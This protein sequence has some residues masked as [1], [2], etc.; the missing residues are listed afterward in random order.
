MP[1]VIDRSLYLV[2]VTA[3]DAVNSYTCLWSCVLIG[4]KFVFELNMK[5]LRFVCYT[6]KP[7]L[8]PTL[9][10]QRSRVG[11]N[12]ESPPPL[13]QRAMRFFTMLKCPQLAPVLIQMNPAHN[14]LPHVSKI[15]FNIT[16]ASISK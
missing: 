16:L 13:F 3:S 6:D 15:H 14:S 10:S 9:L 1:E 7:E 4:T 5:S 12:Q 8:F 11:L 2:V